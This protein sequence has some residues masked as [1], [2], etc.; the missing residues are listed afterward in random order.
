MC[1]TARRRA[2]GRAARLA[3]VGP[4]GM[5]DAEL[6]AIACALPLPD[7]QHL[8]DGTGPRPRLRPALRWQALLALEHRRRS[9]AVARPQVSSA[10]AA[11]ELF[12]P[13]LGSLEVE[14]LHALALDA[15]N[16][17]LRRVVI[18]RG[19]ANQVAVLAREVFRP[20]IAVGAV[21]AII[22]HNHPSGSCEPSPED[23]QLTVRLVA[24][25]ELLGIALLDHLVVAADGYYSF[26]SEGQ[27]RR[28]SIAR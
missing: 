2:A 18:A 1:P 12:A 13:L 10:G 5:S 21:A 20:L 9:A 8:I 14:E 15:R 11:A 6:L 23:R 17:L 24:A 3:S 4:D 27:L 7:A 19:A 22:A 25:G 28:T 16:R 26:A